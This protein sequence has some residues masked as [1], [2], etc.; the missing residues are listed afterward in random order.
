M[1]E[2]YY[3]SAA[4][5]YVNGAPHLGHAL[6]IVIAD[7]LAR[8]QR[9]RDRD[10]C[11]VSGTD[12]NSLK[13]VRAAECEQVSVTE[14]VQRNAARFLE[15]WSELEVSLD[16][17][18][19]TSSDPRHSATVHAIWQGCERSGDI[20]RRRYHGLY[21]VGCEQYLR[22]SDLDAGLCPEH[23]ASPEPI[24]EENYFFRLSRYQEPLRELVVSGAL[25]ILPKEREHE[26]LR[27]IEGGLED[28]S[29][30]RAALRAR[31]W[32]IAVPGDPREVVFVWFDA[33][34]N[35]L[36]AL[37]FAAASTRYRRFW[38]TNSER[39]HVV[40]KGILRF[41]AVYWPAILL[42][43]GLPLPT[44]VLVHGYV[45][46]DGRKVGKSLGN[47]VDPFELCR[48]HGAAA[49][50]Y[51]LLRHIPTTKDGDFS[52]ERLSEAYNAELAN[53]LGNLLQRT[54]RLVD[55]TPPCSGEPGQ[56]ETELIDEA[57]QARHAVEDAFA[58]FDLKQALTAIWRLLA[59]ANRYADQTAPW[60]RLRELE[61]AGNSEERRQAAQRLVT[62]VA[63][64]LEALR[65][66][67]I[68]LAPLLPSTATEM[69]RRIGAADPSRVGWRGASFRA[70]PVI[71]QVC[72]SSPLFPRRK[73]PLPRPIVKQH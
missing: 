62:S 24:E 15:L 46:A 23:G 50:R 66:T 16:Q 67:S 73:P 25:R 18:V 33:L 22:P 12:D 10:V 37:D 43:A 36:S 21:C 54:V 6:E 55:A 32:G 26:V 8:Y 40:G 52:A 41:H 27:F 11:F 70:A 9:L 60:L 17:I 49:V 53:Q 58:M 34:C 13:A 20:Y 56:A 7:S 28:F 57:E 45:T 4:L 48:L 63:H 71:G 35:Y 47:S 2:P 64:L 61:Q 44:Q 51:Y 59:T 38:G 69:A 14:L 3:V 1:N 29:I 30:S 19:H 31:G 39:I 65:V 68:L 42:S 5:P 72:A